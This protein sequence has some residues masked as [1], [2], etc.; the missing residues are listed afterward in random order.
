M[1]ADFLVQ[2][3]ER[4]LHPLTRI[5]SDA[6]LMNFMALSDVSCYVSCDNIVISNLLRWIS[7]GPDYEYSLRQ[8]IHLSVFY[9][10]HSV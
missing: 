8:R 5:S 4:I 3:L 10:L 7:L 9:T 2:F 6:D 1:K